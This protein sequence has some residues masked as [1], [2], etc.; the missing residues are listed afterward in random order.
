MIAICLALLP[1]GLVAGPPQR[2]ESV[3]LP[4]MAAHAD[5]IPEFTDAFLDEQLRAL[6]T[7][8]P[9][10]VHRDVRSFI[11]YYTTSRRGYIREVQRL[12]TL[13]FPIYKAYLAEYGLPE[14]LKYLSIV[15]SGLR[16]DAISRSGAGGLW[17]FMPRT[18]RV[19]GLRYDRYVDERRDYMAATEAACRYLKKLHARFG[20]WFLALAAFNAGEGR[21]SRAMRRSGRQS[22]WKLR[23][24]LPKETRSYVPQFIAMTYVM[25]RAHLHN[26]FP[27]RHSY[28]PPHISLQVKTPLHLPTLAA[29]MGAKEEELLLLNPQYYRGIV[30]G[31]RQS[32]RLPEHHLGRYN[33]DK[34]SILSMAQKEAETRMKSID[35]YRM[36]MYAKNGFVNRRRILYRVRRGDALSVIARRYGVRTSNVKRWNRLRNSHRIRAGQRLVLWVP[37]TLAARRSG[38]SNRRAGRKKGRIGNAYIVQS[39]DSLWSISRE[40]DH[41]TTSKLK[42]INNLR[43]NL[44]KPG[45]RLQLYRD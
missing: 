41:L 24:F 8:I 18:G 9:M 30:P 5:Y 19:F 3:P 45:Q 31:G 40:Y 4:R 14:V 1:L 6:H 37:R 17:Q 44:I 34:V 42:R 27:E 39:G 28:L 16:A 7:E 26:L 21:V 15:E 38:G 13:Y 12:S 32:I 10:T 29:G 11:R 43:S 23:K 20:D 35:K 25:R 36:P 22:Y 33:R 2:G